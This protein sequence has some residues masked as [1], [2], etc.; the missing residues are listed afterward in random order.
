MKKLLENIVNSVKEVG[1]KIIIG[2][3]ISSLF[4]LPINAGKIKIA[5]YTSSGSVQFSSMYTK[6]LSDANEAEDYADNSTFPPYIEPWLKIH[7]NPYGEE[8]ETDA[9]PLN[10]PEVKFY[11]SVVGNINRRID[12]SLKIKV[13]DTR[14]LEYREVIA[15][16]VNNPSDFNE[17][18]KDGSY[19]TVALP[20]LKNPPEGI[21]ATWHIAT[22][23]IVPGDCG[24][25][26]GPGILDGQKD[27]Y[28]VATVCSK[29]LEETFEGE[30]YF[31]G[32]LNY[33]GINDFIDYTIAAN[34]N[35]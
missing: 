32:D 28:D 30:N 20:D 33:D 26:A 12:N 17:I 35:Y 3:T 4:A 22:P 14:G 6:Y 15:Y 19:H 8:L 7:S 13:E 21:Y 2:T 10:T 31:D 27:I 9:R 5:N 16:D 11:L 1:K 29:W 34:N 18:P 23:P 24:S 25:A